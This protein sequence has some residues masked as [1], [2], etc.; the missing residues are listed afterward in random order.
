MP[1]YIKQPKNK[2]IK[3]RKSEYKQKY[4]DIYS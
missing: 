1:D 2:L 3:T 4:K